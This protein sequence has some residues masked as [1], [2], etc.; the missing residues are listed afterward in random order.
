MASKQKA[1]FST[2]I[3]VMKHRKAP[4][5]LALHPEFRIKPLYWWFPLHSLLKF[6]LVPSGYVLRSRMSEEKI[7]YGNVKRIIK[8]FFFIIKPLFWLPTQ[9][10][11]ESLYANTHENS[12]L[13][14]LSAY[15]SM[16]KLFPHRLHHLCYTLLLFCLGP[17]SHPCH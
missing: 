14:F 10:G 12:L 6:K 3:E 2:T 15:I 17:N 9:L 16:E 7:R 4:P 8:L 5:T 11:F 13:L 1:L